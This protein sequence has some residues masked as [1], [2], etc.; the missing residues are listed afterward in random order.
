MSSSGGIKGKI[1]DKISTA[2]QKLTDRP[3]ILLITCDQYRFPRFSYGADAGFHQGLKEILGFQPLSADNPYVKYFPGLMR[4]RRNA[5]VLRNHMIAASA[6]TPSRAVIYTGQYGTRTGR[7]PDRRLFKNGDAPNFPWLDADGIPTLG[8]WMRHAGYTT[9]YFGKWHVSNPPEHS[10]KRWGFDDWEASYPEPHG[11]Q[12]NNLGIYRDVGFT[13]SACAFIRRMGL[14]NNYNRVY[15]NMLASDPNS[16]GPKIDSVPW[17]AVGLLHQSA[18]HRDLS[19]RREPGA[20]RQAVRAA[21][22]AAAIHGRAID[23]DAQAHRRADGDR[24]QSVRL[25]AGLR[26]SLADAERGSLHQAVLPAGILLQDG[27]RARLQARLQHRGRDRGRHRCRGGGDAAQHHPVPAR[28]QGPG[29]RHDGQSAGRGAERGGRQ[30]PGVPAA[31]CVAA[32]R[33]RQARQRRADR[34][35]RVRTGRQPPS[36]SSSPITAST[37]PRTA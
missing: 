27:A 6:C 16:S 31:L 26:Q 7:H 8:T 17:F 35:R 28:R 33:R 29:R 20:R 30:Q 23:Q 24:A 5:V 15:A 13:D 1:K 4:L 19:R 10:L 11:S 2:V 34:A 21:L 25:P 9:H 14:A 37:A 18:R 22:R 36:S 32:H 3:N 12:A